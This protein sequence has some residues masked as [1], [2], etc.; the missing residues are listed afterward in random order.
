MF[1]ENTEKY[2]RKGIKGLLTFITVLFQY[3]Q[4]RVVF[5][6]L[7]VLCSVTE[8]KREKRECLVDKGIVRIES[9]DIL[10]RSA[11]TAHYFDSCSKNGNYTNSRN[12]T[13][14][15]NVLKV[16]RRPRDPNYNSRKCARGPK[17]QCLRIE[18]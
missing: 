3:R 17:V 9:R 11:D 1:C 15:F 12:V 4:L 16:L 6:R 18:R 10:D 14:A 7:L 5:Y 8:T 13:E 2:S